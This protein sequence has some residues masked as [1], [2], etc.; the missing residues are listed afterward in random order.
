MPKNSKLLVFL[1]FLAFAL[2]N[3]PLLQIFNRDLCLA[4]VPLLI[5]YLFGVW[6]VAIVVLYWGQRFLLS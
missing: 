4:G 3:Y 6:L 1:G 5:Y 2:F